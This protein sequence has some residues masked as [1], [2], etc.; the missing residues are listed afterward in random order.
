MAQMTWRTT[1]EILERVRRQ[2]EHAGRSFYDWVTTVLDVASDPL[3][4]GSGAERIRERLRRAGLLESPTPGARR[5]SGPA[6]LAEERAAAG[7]G[8]PLSQLVTSERR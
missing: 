7:R 2:A 5:R 1:V 3:M 6:P 4:A 8:I